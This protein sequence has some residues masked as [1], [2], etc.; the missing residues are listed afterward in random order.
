MKR[1]I[2]AMTRLLP[3]LTLSA[4]VTLGSTGHAQVATTGA[5][6][7]TAVD[8]NGEPLPG[9]RVT[10]TL[11]ANPA[12]RRSTVTDG[13]GRYQLSQL[14]V[15]TYDVTF[16]L[17]GFK[18]QVVQGVTIPAETKMALTSSMT[19]GPIEE[20]QAVASDATAV[21]PADD[22]SPESEVAPQRLV[23]VLPQYPRD[24]PRGTAGTVSVTLNVD[25]T[26]RPF[27]VQPAP[28]HDISGLREVGGV[29]ALAP[30]PGPLFRDAVVGAVTQ[31]VYPP[32]L[33]DDVTLLVQF[34]F[35]AEGR[36]R[37]VAHQ[38][39]RPIPVSGPLTVGL[40]R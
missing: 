2:S 4:L 39:S 14:P 35:L 10:V 25:A 32:P 38:L 31:W 12:E 28:E 34:T 23:T 16:D 20:R 36:V 6:V 24:A 29:L 22:P 40:T 13:R 5:L 26:G 33:Q 27:N 37:L 11:L 1:T 7:G 9:T 8:S 30:Q 18:R 15:G 3:V 21:G 19:P 17:I